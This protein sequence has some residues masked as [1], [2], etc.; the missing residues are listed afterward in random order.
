LLLE[1]GGEIPYKESKF[2][3]EVNVPTPMGDVGFQALIDHYS[4]AVGDL[5]KY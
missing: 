1:L 3:R 5:Q 2:K 4:T